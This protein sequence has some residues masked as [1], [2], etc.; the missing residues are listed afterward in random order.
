MLH[1]KNYLKSILIGVYRRSKLKKLILL[2]VLPL[3]IQ[4][5]L[6]PFWGK[7]NAQYVDASIISI[8]VCLLTPIYLVLI[9][10]IYKHKKNMIVTH[11]IMASIVI[12]DVFF[13]H[14]GWAGYSHRFFNPDPMTKAFNIFFLQFGLF[15]VALSFIISLIIKLYKRLKNK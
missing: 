5:V 12:I 11:I 1:M 13:S 6:I 10:I 4:I 2:A 3:F 9:N 7:T 14:I 8:I 15:F